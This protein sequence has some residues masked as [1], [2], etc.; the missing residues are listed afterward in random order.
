[1]VR[2]ELAFLPEK[3]TPKRRRLFGENEEEKDAAALPP[4]KRP[5]TQGKEKKKRKESTA[6]RP[7]NK[8]AQRSPPAKRKPNGIITMEP[9]AKRAVGSRPLSRQAEGA[10]PLRGLQEALKE[11]GLDDRAIAKRTEQGSELEYDRSLI[12]ELMERRERFIAQWRRNRFG[13]GDAAEHRGPAG[14]VPE[15]AMREKERR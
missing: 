6:S 10:A 13:G 14:R 7:S 12:T 4:C 11:V 9:T 15:P 8:A 3:R 5:R 1:M 2:R